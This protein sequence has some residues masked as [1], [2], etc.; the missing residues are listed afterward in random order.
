SDGSGLL[1]EQDT[2]RLAKQDPVHDLLCAA[3]H[4]MEVA[5]ATG[6]M[7]R[8]NYGKYGARGNRIPVCY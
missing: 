7:R 4:R 2:V 6:A 3:S 1:T 5:G 8:G